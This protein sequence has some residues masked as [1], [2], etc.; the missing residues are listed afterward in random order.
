MAV[1]FD[2]ELG[3]SS[4]RRRRW[5]LTAK[6]LDYDAKIT[7]FASTKERQGT[8]GSADAEDRC[9]QYTRFITG[10]LGCGRESSQSAFHQVATFGTA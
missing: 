2:G 7:D 3:R 6:T 1:I 9:T 8:L 10:F 4:P 5:Q